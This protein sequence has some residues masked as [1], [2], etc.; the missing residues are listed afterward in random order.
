MRML[1]IAPHQDDEILSSAILIQKY[2]QS[3]NE[4]F[5]AFVTNGDYEGYD[6]AVL[7]YYESSY[8]LDKLG[9]CENH[10]YYMG[11]GDTGMQF[12]HSFLYRLFNS[13]RRQ[14]CSSLI[15]SE[16]YHPVGKMTVHNMYTG[17]EADYCRESLLLDLTFLFYDCQPDVLIIPSYFDRH[18]DHLGCELFIRELMEQEK[19]DIFL[20]EYFLHTDDDCL[21]P[22]R[23]ENRF[24]CPKN[25]PL[26]LWERRLVL[27]A[28]EEERKKK[29]ECINCFKTQLLN[30]HSGYLHSFAKQEECF[31]LY[32][33]INQS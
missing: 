19:I 4:V 5:I 30:D 12:D 24:T 1:V 14:I 27:P 9:I 11:Y 8:A 21:W 16:T 29:I 20:I 26:L 25:I 23:I 3:G 2:I 17:K 13:E 10:I 31:F 32:P 28:S 18:G 7:R 33:I 22:D 15:S 6:T